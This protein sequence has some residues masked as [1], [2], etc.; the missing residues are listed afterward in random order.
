[1]D[2]KFFFSNYTDSISELL[3]NVDT[4]LI[5]ASVNLIANTKKNKNKIYIVGNGGSSSIASHV[6][7]DFTKVAK[8]N[9]ST[10]NNVNLITCFA[11][12]YKYENWVVEAI[13]AYSLEQDLFILISSSGTSK[14]IVNAAEYCKQKKM[15]LITLS[16]FKKNNPLSQSGNINFHVESE[17]YNF[18]EMTHHIILLSIVD[19]F[20]KKI[21]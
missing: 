19:I 20:A 12:D 21:Y 2:Y 4:N 11:N 14:N 18:I 9:C 5:N 15:N 16:G 17:E 8:I 1:M 3:K 13:K 10:F 6:S 7:V